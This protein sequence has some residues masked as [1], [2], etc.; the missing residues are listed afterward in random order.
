MC[1]EDEGDA[2][3]SLLSAEPHWVGGIGPTS[4]VQNRHLTP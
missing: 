4:S 1:C 3:G 2:T